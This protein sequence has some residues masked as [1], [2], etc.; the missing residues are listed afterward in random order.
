MK[1][2]ELGK[3]IEGILDE[4]IKEPKTPLHYRDPFTLFVAVLLSASTSDERVN[5]VT[6]K[7]FK[8]APTAEKMA[9]CS[10]EEVEKI[11]RPLGLSSSKAKFLIAS[12][13]ILQEKYRGKIP[14][15][16]QAL[17]ELPGV[18]HKTAQVVLQVA[19][20]I[21]GFPVDTHIFRC[22]RRWG[23]SDKK[24]RLG[25]EKEL[26]KIFPEEKWGRLHLQIT[27]AGRRY[28]MARSHKR[29]RCAICSRL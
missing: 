16:L 10:E 27:L 3:K 15:D 6:V 2:K 1:K 8:L 13:K 24:T 4:L 20:N 7:L 11:I 28:C 19:Y 17:E 12:S 23:L 18:G 9:A 22:A 14:K 26:K 25:V 21:P 29:E 5:E